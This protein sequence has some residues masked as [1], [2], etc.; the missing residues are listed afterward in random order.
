MA[1][2]RVTALCGGGSTDG[3]T[4]T[5]NSV[6]TTGATL[7]VVLGANYQGSPAPA[8]TDSKSNSW[9]G[10]VVSASHTDTERVS[11]WYSIPT[12]V[13][14]GHTFT[15]TQTTSYPSILV[16][17]FSGGAASSVF[18]QSNGNTVSG[19]STIQTG[20]VTPSQDNELLMTVVSS[21]DGTGASTIDSGF[22]L[23]ESV[24]YSAGLRFGC[25]VSF[26][27]QTAAGAENPTW[28]MAAATSASAVIATFKAAD[29]ATGNPWYYYAQQ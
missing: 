22:S 16:Y 21:G 17:G 4:V 6:D 8:I 28:T 5:S 11:I 26:K 1:F 9:T 27:I 3:N 15:A 25:A 12:S 29:V 2:A 14:S 23:K 19:P 18:D 13:G 10:P 20:S 7:L 24:L